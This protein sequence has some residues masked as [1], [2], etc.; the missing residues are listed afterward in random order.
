ADQRHY[1]PTILASYP[2]PSDWSAPTQVDSAPIPTMPAVIG[3]PG[4]QVP[5][6]ASTRTRH[7]WFA[8]IAVSIAFVLTLGLL[9]VGIPQVFPH[10]AEPPKGAQG[11]T[12]A[13]HAQRVVEQF[14]QHINA[15]DYTA[16]YALEK[17]N[18]GQGSYCSLVDGYML[19]ERDDVTYNGVTK[20][21]DGTF[22]VA[23]TI[24]ATELFARGSVK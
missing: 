6:P 17:T 21:P 13:Q 19:T 9:L 22:T 24:V 10:P 11:P 23:I 3:S 2:P 14:Y 4:L 1:A 8:W 18:S 5:R 16:A 15:R 7:S 20:L 12:P